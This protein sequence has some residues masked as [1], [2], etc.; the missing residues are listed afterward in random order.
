[1]FFN[2]CI[3]YTGKINLDLGGPVGRTVLPCASP[4]LDAVLGTGGS[5]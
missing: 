1:M 5:M 2:L 4:V 3:G